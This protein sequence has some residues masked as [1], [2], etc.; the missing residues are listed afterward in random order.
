MA[1]VSQG[2]QLSPTQILLWR[3]HGV[4]VRTS[5]S[6]LMEGPVERIRLEESLRLLASRHEIL[7]TSYIQ[8]QGV[9]VPLQ[10]IAG[11]SEVEPWY[12]LTEAEPG[13]LLLKVS[14]PAFSVDSKSAEN[15]LAE[16]T[17]AYASSDL[18]DD[19]IQYADFSEWQRETIDASDEQAKQYWME[20]SGVS[21]LPF[22]GTQSG[23]PRQTFPLQ[24]AKYRLANTP[25]TLLACWVAVL[26]RFTDCNEISVSCEMDGRVSDELKPAIGLFGHPVPMSLALESDSTFA[27]LIDQAGRVGAAAAEH[28]THWLPMATADWNKSIGFAYHRL[29]DPVDPDGGVRFAL[30]ELPENPWPYSL[31]LQCRMQGD[32]VHAEISFDGAR[33]TDSQ[34]ATLARSLERALKVVESDP[35]A[36]VD[37]FNLLS[38]EELS[39]ALT[40]AAGPAVELA[41][42]CFHELFE[43]R[44]SET[45][46]APALRFEEEL[47]SYNEANQRA[48]RLA[49][50][51]RSRNTKRSQ[52]IGLCMERSAGMIVALLGILKAGSAYLPISPETPSA[53][54]AQFL[55]ESK[56]SLVVT[57]RELQHLFD[58]AGV[59]VICI[60]EV[61]AGLPD[62][63]PEPVATP[64][65]LAYVIYTSGST[66]SPK[67]VGVRHRNLVHYTQGICQRLGL[68]DEKLT[69]ATV[70][71]LAADLGNTSI[72]PALATGGQLCI[73]GRDSAL[74]SAEFGQLNKRY[75]IDVLKIT[76]SN[77]Q[78]LLASGDP[79]AILPKR[80]LILG[81]EAFQWDLA[82]RI[83]ALGSPSRSV[84]N[85]YGPTETT[86]GCL[87]YQLADA[88]DPAETWSATVP[89]GRPLP[90]VRV[91]IL[92]RQLRPVPQG[93][94]GEI[95][96]GG[97]GVSA[98]YVGRAE[99][100]AAKFVDDPAGGVCYRTGDRGR[101][102][103]D[104][105]IEFLGRADG[106]V[107]IRGHRVE[108][109]EI[110]TV[111]SAHPGVGQA[112]VLHVPDEV[113]SGRLIAFVDAPKAEAQAWQQH[114]RRHLPE[115]MVPTDFVVLDQI[116]L[117]ANGKTDRRKLLQMSP[118]SR[119]DSDIN[120]IAPRNETEERLASIWREVL[121]TEQI[122]VTDDFFALGGHSLLATQVAARILAS[123]G[124]QLSIRTLFDATTI[125]TLAKAVQS[126]SPAGSGG[127]GESGSDLLSEIEEM[128]ILEI[129]PEANR[130]N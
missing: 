66:G 51:L 89:L 20:R 125:E 69:F 120:R 15:F 2:F 74:S 4:I 91:Y 77:L 44:V 35:N 73:I 53:R 108:L 16:L 119:G 78:A 13:S 90:G 48:N 43:A 7:R 52:S 117:T 115:Y 14:L 9:A 63:N 28:Q 5:F 45:P 85:H 111:L 70:S 8:P 57:T 107:K 60:E 39:S 26:C 56:A 124:V 64:D 88:A 71:T 17:T 30:T 84:L 99:D 38:A 24:T 116:P 3:T 50:L 54:I 113:G 93:A 92:D 61:P 82:H 47:I 1:A 55:A 87:T 76:P 114:L 29:P 121:G 94:V 49:H 67:G 65:D 6:I 118:V 34:I 41:D 96:I 33:F 130:R 46:D 62:T 103:S 25:D 32:T 23:G 81:G 126:A 83:Q 112:V 80:F 110:E 36:S 59:E 31:A 97:G 101:A 68:G 105:S 127:I 11:E 42:G 102:L 128:S 95:C 122:G 79:S 106:Q 10:V 19:P 27:S 75:Q 100:T 21:E 18:G 40:T 123:F 129:E 58:G 86:V 72:F 22:G 12:E 109:G 98:G 104:G 37:S